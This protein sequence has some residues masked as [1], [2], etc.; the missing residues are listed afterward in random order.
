M[1]DSLIKPAHATPD[2]TA[3]YRDRHTDL[4]GHF[5]RTQNLWLSSIG[6][7][8]YLGQPG[9]QAD[10]DYAAA[11][12]RAVTSG[13]NVIDTASNYRFQRSERAIGQALAGVFAAQTV[14]RNEL[15]I[16]TKGGYIAFD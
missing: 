11:V 8:T 13:L 14:A 16:A 5:R 10:G 9:A 1:S 3:R 6:I 2:G 4:P 15:V 12:K 7:G